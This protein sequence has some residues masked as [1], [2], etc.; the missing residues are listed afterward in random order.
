MAANPALNAALNPPNVMQQA[1]TWLSERLAV[2]DVFDETFTDRAKTSPW[3]CIGGTFY[4]IWVVVLVTGFWLMFW[5]TPT[6]EMGYEAIA[7]IQDKIPFGWFMRA[8]HKYGGDAM[9][10]LAT[11]RAYRFV[12]SGDYKKPY[13]LVYLWSVVAIIVCMYSGLTGYL[14]IWNQR[15]FWATKVM[16]TF[17]TYIDSTPGLGFQ[18]FGR[19]T[20]FWWL[21]GGSIGQ[22]TITNFFT[23]HYALSV[24]AILIIEQ[25][26][27]RTKRRR[28]NLS[29]QQ[30]VITMVILVAVVF[31][32]PSEMGTH[33]NPT[34]TPNP[35]LSDWYFLALYQLMKYQHPVTATWVTVVIPAVAI[36]CAFLDIRPERSLWQRPGMAVVAI[37]AFVQW[38]ALSVL[39]IKNIADIA[40]DPP[41]WYLSLMLPAIPAAWLEWRHFQKTKVT[42]GLWS[43]PVFA[44]TV[45]GTESSKK[46]AA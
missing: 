14:L 34:V 45:I 12:F 17:P 29:I 25:Y 3:Y 18:Y 31:M 40:R 15:A 19:N 20:A 9:I 5:Y 37:G 36:L 1:L 35:I 11:M 24:I 38:I 23:A 8:L 46:K 2:M 39:I 26:F 27:W 22:G 44:K 28:I 42:K 10:I 4:F 33:S 41:F 43:L 7:N 6:V 13:E 21:G 32:R 30:M 16:V